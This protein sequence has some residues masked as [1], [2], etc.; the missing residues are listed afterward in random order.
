MFSKLLGQ[1][2]YGLNDSGPKMNSHSDEFILKFES[3]S[4]FHRHKT[5]DRKMRTS[6]LFA[7]S[8]MQWYFAKKHSPKDSLKECLG[9]LRGTFLKHTVGLLHSKALQ[10]ILKHPRYATH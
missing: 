8:S 5:D 7:Q 1:N 4:E 9:A 10:N 6:F 2:G 3:V